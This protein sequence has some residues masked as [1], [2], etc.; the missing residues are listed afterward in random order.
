MGLVKIAKR[1]DV[2]FEYE[3]G[4]AKAEILAGECPEASFFRCSLLPG[5]S[6][7]PPVYSTV[8][9]SQVFLFLQGDGYVVTPRKGFNVDDK[10]C[11]FVPDYDTEKF[12]IVCSSDSKKPLEYIHI[13]TELNDYDKHCLYASKMRLP[14]FRH[15]EDG[16]EYYESFKSEDV[17]SVMLL[18]HRNLGRVSCG[19]VLGKGP[20]EV[21]QHVHN[22]ILQWYIM[23]P[24]SKMTYTA[25]DES[26]LLEGGDI[27]FT[28]TGYYHGSKV[29]E[30]DTLNYVWYE[31]V[32]DCYPGEI[33]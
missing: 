1:K 19:A 23:L 15:I 18:E 4:Y 28:P 6:V 8:E 11:V 30:G 20:C 13:I 22:E 7:K 3:N 25:G 32:K 31:M 5:S 29:A 16:W 33:E 10:F 17:K 27:S 21:G 12:E 26:V 14:R 2:E 9:H 24:G